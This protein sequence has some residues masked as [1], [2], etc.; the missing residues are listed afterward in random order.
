MT[1]RPWGALLR[2]PRD[3]AWEANLDRAL[4]LHPLGAAP[5]FCSSAQA[6]PKS[7]VHRFQLPGNHSRAMEIEY[8]SP[9]GLSWPESFVGEDRK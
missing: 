7:M 3:L 1:P 2:F 6:P 8:V 9:S 4:D 5:Q